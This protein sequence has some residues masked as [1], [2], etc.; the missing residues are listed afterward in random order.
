MIF[1]LVA[2]ASLVIASDNQNKDVHSIAELIKRHGITV[3]H[4]VPSLLELDS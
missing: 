4:F 3:L 2:G 1:P